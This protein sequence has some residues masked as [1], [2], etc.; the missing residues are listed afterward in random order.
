MG[1]YY[2]EGKGLDSCNIF[3]KVMDDD[4]EQLQK[5][6]NEIWRHGEQEI[7]FERIA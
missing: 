2:G 5:L 6:G 3:A 7:V 1:I 4:M